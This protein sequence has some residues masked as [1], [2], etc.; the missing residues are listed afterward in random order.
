MVAIALLDMRSE[1]FNVYDKVETLIH[2]MIYY[3]I[4]C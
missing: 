3:T 2:F 4:L 1:D